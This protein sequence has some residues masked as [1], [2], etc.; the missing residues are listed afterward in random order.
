[1]HP[2]EGVWLFKGAVVTNRI[3]LP[4][5]GNFGHDASQGPSAMPTCTMQVASNY[6]FHSKPPKDSPMSDTRTCIVRC[7]D[8]PTIARI[9]LSNNAQVTPPLKEGAVRQHTCVDEAYIRKIGSLQ[10]NRDNGIIELIPIA[11]VVCEP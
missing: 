6:S 7:K 1:M 3:S 8:A 2:S 5:G 4:Y 9:R 10:W 11:V